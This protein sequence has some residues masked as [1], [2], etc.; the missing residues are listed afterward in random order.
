MFKLSTNQ[1]KLN[2]IA[3]GGQAA[4]LEGPTRICDVGAKRKGLRIGVG[5]CKVKDDCVVY[6]MLGLVCVVS[7]QTCVANWHGYGAITN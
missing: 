3:S 5:N 1:T 6:S 7:V 2:Y 4:S